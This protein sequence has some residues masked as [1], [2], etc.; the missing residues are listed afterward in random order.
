MT[1]IWLTA[2]ALTLLAL[3]SCGGVPLPPIPLPDATVDL[4]PSSEVI[5]RVIY[6]KQDVLA[7]A[8]L[9][10]QQVSITGTATYVSG[11]GN[12]SAANIFIRS[13]LDPLPSGC[14]N[15]TLAPVIL[16]DPAGEG[17]RQIGAVA[18]AAGQGNAF[19]LSGAALDGAAKAGHGY[20]GVQV[21]AGSSV[22][23]DKL[24]LTGM[25]ARARF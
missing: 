5:G 11:G 18:L 9:P 1:K 15:S 23:T 19:V 22:L 14:I 25:Q 2:A 24:R 8:G 17:T 12:L 4:P 10:V 13:S 16:C 3:T 6:I 20:I 21:T 7:G